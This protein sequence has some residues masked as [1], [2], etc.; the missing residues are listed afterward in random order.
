[1]GGV[2]DRAAGH[3]V[4]PCLLDEH[5]HHLMGSDH[6]H[7]VVGVHDDGGGGL[8]DDVDSGD[9]KQGAVLNP[10]QIN[11]LKAVAPMAL[12]TPAVRF[13][14]HIGADL[15]VVLRHA[16]GFEHIDHK[17]FNQIPCDIRSG[18]HSKYLQ[19]SFV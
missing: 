1:M 17:G 7:S 9:G 11:G 6:A 14:Q 2:E 10:V 15:C 5:V 16:I 12:N 18:L 19:L 8:F 4:D 3:T 13:Q